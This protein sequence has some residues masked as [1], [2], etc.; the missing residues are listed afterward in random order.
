MKRDRKQF[1]IAH[2]LPS[3]AKIRKWEIDCEIKLGI[4][5]I[6]PFY[7]RWGEEY[8]FEKATGKITR[9]EADAKAIVERDLNL[10]SKSDGVIAIID[11]NLS[12]GTIQEMVY[13]KLFKKPLFIVVTNGEEN[14]PW[15]RYH[16]TKIFT[17]FEDLERELAKYVNGQKNESSK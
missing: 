8:Q 4:I 11:G 5:L 10:I 17:S 14:H 9:Y 6:N 16:A 2:P 1:Y 3:K 12:Y 13:A 7:N 15:F